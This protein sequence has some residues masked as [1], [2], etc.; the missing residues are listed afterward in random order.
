MV[1]SIQLEEVDD[2]LLAFWE[3]KLVDLHEKWRRKRS[4]FHNK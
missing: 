3:K 2:I 1:D 4:K